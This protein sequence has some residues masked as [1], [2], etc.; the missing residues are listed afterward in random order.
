MSVQCNS[1]HMAINSLPDEAKGPSTA[2]TVLCI[3]LVAL[4][5]RPGIVSIGPLLPTI[6]QELGLSYI[7]ASL[8][9]SIP[10]FLMGALALPAPWL[11]HRFG[12]DRAILVALLV[13]GGAMSLRTVVD[14]VGQLFITTAGVGAGIA[15][16]GTLLSGYVKARFPGRVAVF[17]GLYTTSIALGSTLAAASTGPLVQAAESW[18]WAAGFWILPVVLAVAV[19]VCVNQNGR[20]KQ[21]VSTSSS[22]APRLPLRNPTA[23][24][25]ALFFACNNLVFYAMIAWL[26]PLYIELGNTPTAAGMILASYT[27][28]FVVATTLFGFISRNDDRRIVLAV[29]AGIALL[30]SLA[31]AIAPNTLPMLWVPLAAF[32]TGGAFTLAMTLPLDNASNPEEANA[33]SAFVMLPSYIVAAGGPLLTGYLRDIS[34]NFDLSLWMLVVVGMVMLLITPFLQPN[35]NNEVLISH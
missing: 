28:G 15:I 16:A 1:P 19:W 14:S 27:L 32:G 24:L 11:A 17:M 26:A 30:G 4:T 29:S 33:W 9:T 23:W 34:D 8:L 6:I 22:R 3:V 20:Q 2:I 18:R 35:R 13:M 21:T 31:I 25:I 10:T 12:R 7:Q 5:L